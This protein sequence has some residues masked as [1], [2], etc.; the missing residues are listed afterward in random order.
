MKEFFDRL[1]E[2]VEPSRNDI[3]EK[4]FHLHRILRAFSDDEHL[5][6]NLVFKGGT[7]LIKAYMGYFRFSED[8]DFTWR[9]Q[10]MW[11]GMTKSRVNRKCS[12]LITDI[13]EILQRIS[14]SL[15]LEF[16]ADK[17]DDRYIQIGSGGRMVTFF[18]WY[19]SEVTGM[20]SMLKVQ[21]NFVE[22]VEHPV[23]TMDLKSLITGIDLD[24]ETEYLFAS[25]VNEYREEISFPCYGA[26]EIYTEKCRAALT[27]IAYKLR[28]I[29]DI[30]YIER[31]YGY[32]IQE[33]KKEIVRK[34]VL[35]IQ[36][37]SRYDRRFH[38]SEFPQV[39][40]L[41][42]EEMKL[43]LVEPPEDLTAE[44]KRVHEELE[45]VRTEIEK[46]L[47]E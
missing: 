4:D 45:V 46:D 1:N 33:M 16:K 22:S 14:D 37:Y 44:I 40:S 27:R 25:S 47:S 15:G 23:N 26:Q 24:E 35:M 18:I 13:G 32:S 31:R 12:G 3:I 42:N 6:E 39:D 10:D 28:D 11:P 43:M 2:I 20:K 19:T 41:D 7:C 34:T 8:L 29:I 5:R 38:E 36:S 9:D 30:V 21:V 17:D